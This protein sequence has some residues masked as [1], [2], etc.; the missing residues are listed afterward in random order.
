MLFADDLMPAPPAESILVPRASRWRTVPPTAG[1]E[2]EIAVY[3]TESQHPSNELDALLR[4]VVDEQIVGAIIVPPDA[5]WLYHPYDGGVDV[6]AQS[7]RACAA[8]RE[9]F[10][11]WLSPHPGGL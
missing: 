6:I 10:G 11:A 9:R 2:T 5:R 3:A 4:A 8:L 7:P 1:E